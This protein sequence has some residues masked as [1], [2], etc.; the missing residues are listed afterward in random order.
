M[1][2]FSSRLFGFDKFSLSQ[3]RF[4]KFS[5][6]KFRFS[7]FGFSKFSFSTCCFSSVGFRKF[8]CGKLSCCKV[9]LNAFCFRRFASGIWVWGTCNGR[10]GEPRKKLSFPQ[11]VKSNRRAGELTAKA[12][13]D[14]ATATKPNS[15]VCY[16]QPC[17]VEQCCS[18]WSA[19]SSR[20]IPAMPVSKAH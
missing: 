13:A 12:D 20:H 14:A 5:F 19:T 2:Q 3:V 1:H 4:S 10:P 17:E 11:S 18:C 6:S 8:I 9:S 16:S 15:C 7:A